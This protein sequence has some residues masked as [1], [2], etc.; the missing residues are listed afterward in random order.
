[1]TAVTVVDSG[2]YWWLFGKVVIVGVMILLES[3]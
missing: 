2:E 3:N 1:M